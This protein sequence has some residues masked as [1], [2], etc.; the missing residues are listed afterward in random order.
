[1]TPSLETSRL[2][3]RPQSLE[4][5]EQIQALFPQWE[6]V[7]N[8]AAVVPWPYPLDGALTWTRDVVLPQMERGEGWH[9][10]LRLKSHPDRV[11][12]VISLKAGGDNNRGFWMGLPWQGQGLM[13]EAADAVTDF[14]FDVLGFPVLR[15]P[16]SVRNAASR[17]ISERQG[18][19]VIATDERD[20]VGGRE[21]AEIWE[22][23]AEE[24]RARRRT[25][26][27]TPSSLPVPHRAFLARCEAALRADARFV[28]LA[29]G[30]SYLTDTM[31]E[32]SD[33]D[34]VVVVEPLA[35][36]EVLADRKALAGTLGT[37]LAAFTG[38]HVGEPRLLICLYGDPLL[39]VD[40]K[41]VALE[42]AAQRVEDPAVIWERDGRLSQV[43]SRGRAEFPK[44]DP[45]WL[46]DRV[47]TWVHYAA[48]KIAR[49]ELFEA[50]DGLAFL[51]GRV[52]GPLALV[53]AGGRPAGVRRIERDAPDVARE[54]L[55]TVARVEAADCLRALRACIALYRDLR[56]SSVDAAASAAAE[57]A[58]VGYV[59]DVARAVER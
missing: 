3:L 6:I 14:W 23:T 59:D 13:S 28:G 33:L 30:G 24:W 37:L 21:T 17:R 11:I 35:Y 27:M 31:D 15:V 12:G 25:R 53:R 2:W 54:L 47:W 19:R 41:F 9:W 10:T 43:L 22:L 8:L 32:F 4:D 57:A 26:R 40:L 42:D 52:L 56:P 1:M 45:Q 20:F 49:G 7:R 16:K 5:V 48:G 50:L 39:H 34:L 29:A 18:M 58:A 51:R 46:D 38:E 55:A 36:D 44:P